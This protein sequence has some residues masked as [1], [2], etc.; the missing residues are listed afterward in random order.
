MA[1]AVMDYASI[2]EVRTLLFLVP[3]CT[4]KNVSHHLLGTKY[5]NPALFLFSR[6]DHSKS[7]PH[8]NKDSQIDVED[9]D[10]IPDQPFDEDAYDTYPV[11]YPSS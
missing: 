8:Q 7:I 1:P 4:E 6:R 2:F 5:S 10:E 9:D 11:I 3:S